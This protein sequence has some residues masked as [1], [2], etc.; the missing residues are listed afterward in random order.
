MLNET[1]LFDMVSGIA[2]THAESYTKL[3]EC[4]SIYVNAHKRLYRKGDQVIVENDKLIKPFNEVP[5]HEII[6]LEGT[7]QDTKHVFTVRSLSNNEVK[8]IE[9]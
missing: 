9:L 6:K 4:A 2:K 8:T 7:L 3:Y 1:K 5:T